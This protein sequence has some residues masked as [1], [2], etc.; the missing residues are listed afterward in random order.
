MTAPVF[1]NQSFYVYI[2]H[3]NSSLEIKAKQLFTYKPD[4]EITNIY[5]LV[6]IVE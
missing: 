5:P 6:S 1:A 4:P 3:D 2:G